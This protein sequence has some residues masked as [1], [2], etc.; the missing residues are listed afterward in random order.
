MLLF[1]NFTRTGLGLCLDGV[2]CKA[3]ISEGSMSAF[4]FCLTIFIISAVKFLSVSS[5]MISTPIIFT[6]FLS[7]ELYVII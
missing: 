7:G 6:L 5:Q 3:T 2:L 4:V 1:L